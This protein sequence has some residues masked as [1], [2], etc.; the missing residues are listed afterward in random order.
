[1]KKGVALWLWICAFTIM[2]FGLLSACSKHEDKSQLDQKANVENTHTTSQQENNQWVD[3]NSGFTDAL[4][5]E[6]ILQETPQRVAAIG[7]S[8][9]DVWLLAGGTLY[10]VTE[11]V[12]TS[13]LT[14]QW[15]GVIDLGSFKTPSVETMVQTNVDFVLLSASIPEHIAL[16]VQ[17]EE[18]EITHAYFDVE[19]FSD[20]LDMLRILCNVTQREDLY[21]Q[22][23]EA[24][25][26]QITNI[27]ETRPQDIHPSVLFLRAFSTDV[28]AKGSDSMTGH[29][30]Q[31]LGCI[32]IADQTEGLLEDLSLEQIVLQDPD[33][34]FVVTMGASNEK[35]EKVLEDKL[36]SHPA[37]NEL[38]AVKN[39]QLYSLPKELF[40]LKP[41]N[42]WGESYEILADYLYGTSQGT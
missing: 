9:A 14:T 11:D 21:L 1:M 42:R 15:E 19:T 34:I 2:I 24:I 39:G 33:F 29:M 3:Y 18:L 35:A 23:G 4:G 7:E 13:K 28:K 17:L 27:I 16:D 26:T 31:D 32:N 5:R 38:S 12:F 22:H 6:V 8:Y 10:A 30:L 37:W 20:Y 36:T 41:N 25:S 40:H